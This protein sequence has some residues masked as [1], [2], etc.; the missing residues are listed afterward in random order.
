M[1][2]LSYSLSFG[3]LIGDIWTICESGRSHITQSDRLS[4]IFNQ[5]IIIRALII[6]NIQHIILTTHVYFINYIILYN[7]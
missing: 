4:K 2:E 6:D 1:I 5:F 7:H 3:T